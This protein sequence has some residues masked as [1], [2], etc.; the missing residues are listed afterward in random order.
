MSSYEEYM[1]TPPPTTEPTPEPI[2]DGAVPVNSPEPSSSTPT[3]TYDQPPPDTYQAPAPEPTPTDTYNDYESPPPTDT[4]QAPPPSPEPTP[5]D[6]YDQP[7]ADTYQAPPPDISLPPPPPDEYE[8]PPPTTQ[9]QSPDY[10]GGPI[11]SEISSPDLSKDV[12]SLITTGDRNIG[13]GYDAG[14]SLYS[15]VSAPDLMK[16]V[17]YPT[18][19]Y[20]GGSIGTKV[21]APDL[22]KD[23]S[24][25][26]FGT[27]KAP[28]QFG[29]EYEFAMAG[30]PKA[31]TP[32]QDYL[33]DWGVFT[34]SDL[35]KHGSA[36]T[37]RKARL[38]YTNDDFWL[39]TPKDLGRQKGIEAQDRELKELSDLSIIPSGKNVKVPSLADAILEPKSTFSKSSAGGDYD[40]FGGGPF[41]GPDITDRILGSPSSKPQPSGD[42]DDFGG[43]PTGYDITKDLGS[44]PSTR[45]AGGFAIGF[46]LPDSDKDFMGAKAFGLSTES[47]MRTDDYLS[48]IPIP[49]GYTPPTSVY[50][51]PKLSDLSPTNTMR[52]DNAK[53]DQILAALKSNTPTPAGFGLTQ[54]ELQVLKDR[55]VSQGA[56]ASLTDKGFSVVF[57][58]Q[59]TIS[60]TQGLILLDLMKQGKDISDRPLN[61]VDLTYLKDLAIEKG[62]QPTLTSKGFSVSFPEE[63]TIS[64]GQA[65]SIL[66]Q[67]MGGQTPSTPL[68]SL[69]LKYLRDVAVERGYNASLTD[70]GLSVTFGGKATSMDM[71]D[72][73]APAPSSDIIVHPDEFSSLNLTNLGQMPGVKIEKLADGGYTINYKQTLSQLD[74]KTAGGFT[75]D[76]AEGQRLNDYAKGLSAKGYSEAEIVEALRSQ[77]APKQEAFRLALI[78]SGKTSEEA[79]KLARDLF[80]VPYNY[81]ITTPLRPPTIKSK[82]DL[83]QAEG[84]AER[85]LSLSDVDAK[86]VMDDMASYIRTI[87]PGRFGQ[88]VPDL[89]AGVE[90]SP[91]L[92]TGVYNIGIGAG[93]NNMLDFN[94]NRGESKVMTAG[95]GIPGLE[96]DVKAV[97]G[98]ANFLDESLGITKTVVG[99][100]NF[101]DQSLG[102]S[103]FGDYFAQKVKA[104]ASKSFNPEAREMADKAILESPV[105]NSVVNFAKDEVDYYANSPL[106]ILSGERSVGAILGA[107]GL[108]I[109]SSPQAQKSSL[110]YLENPANW[111][112]FAVDLGIQTAIYG[113]ALPKALGLAGEVVSKVGPTSAASVKYLSGLPDILKGATMGGGISGGITF[114]ATGDPIEAGK[115]AVLGVI[116]GG[117]IPAIG[118]AI[119]KYGEVKVFGE[120][121]YKGIYEQVGSEA[122]PLIGKIYNR[123]IFS[124]E[125][126][127]RLGDEAR[128]LISK[129]SGGGIRLGTPSLKD[130]ILPTPE[131]GYIPTS[132]LETKIMLRPEVYEQLG[133]PV[134]EF[135]KAE[136][137]VGLGKMYEKTPSE[138][139]VEKFKRETKNISPE[140]VDVLMENFRNDKLVETVGGSFAQR[141]QMPEAYQRVPGDIDINLNTA[142]PKVAARFVKRQAE[143]LR[144]VGDN[145]EIPADDPLHIYNKT[146]GGKALE[147][148]YKGQ[149][150]E[151]GMSPSA[152]VDQRFGFDVNQPNIKVEGIPT[153]RLGEQL[154]RKV[155]SS[156]EMRDMMNEPFFEGFS[157]RIFNERGLRKTTSLIERID[158]GQKFSELEISKMFDQSDLRSESLFKGKTEDIR[159]EPAPHRTKDIVDAYFVAKTLAESDRAGF[160]G[161]F[162]QAKYTKGLALAEEWKELY[163]INPSTQHNF[164]I[165]LVESATEGK[166][167]TSMTYA[168]RVFTSPLSLPSPPASFTDT[169]RGTSSS[170]ST[171]KSKKSQTSADSLLETPK[172]LPKMGIEQS[173]VYRSSITPDSLLGSLS[174]SILDTKSFISPSTSRP[175][176]K[177]TKSIPSSVYESFSHSIGSQH[178]STPSMPSI[179]SQ[180]PSGKSSK[181]SL[182]RQ[183]SLPQSSFLPPPSRSPPPSSLP[184]PYISPP[185]Q[186]FPPPYR[187]P[188]KIP[189][190]PPPSP[191]SSVPRSPPPSP[192]P[193]FFPPPSRPP[194]S[195]IP[196]PYKPPPPYIPSRPPSPPSSVPRSPPSPPPSIP[197]VPPPPRVEVPRLPPLF[198]GGGGAGGGPRGSGSRFQKYN[199]NNPFRNPLILEQNFGKFITGG[200]STSGNKFG[201]QK[202]LYRNPAKQDDM[203]K[204]LTS[205]TM[206]SK[207]TRGTAKPAS[208]LMSLSASIMGGKTKGKK[209]LRGFAE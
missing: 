17:S 110:E 88:T 28:V 130:V 208:R 192:P 162:R 35:L 126:V 5:T 10:F 75:V 40:D 76:E 124:P 133:V 185:P 191:P 94:P 60:K 118:K 77:L 68:N 70:K 8:S 140:G 67:M 107:T 38:D 3:D 31:N 141:V 172:S 18:D 91:G 197:R 24:S 108:P 150:L 171:T 111:P 1:T 179:I 74:V 11:G 61:T 167:K 125:E 83:F 144:K 29:N 109:I 85:Y 186:S 173:S 86:K 151:E 166:A 65:S 15:E 81:D 165:P 131:R 113:L 33:T 119:P 204:S 58:E 123:T 114:A 39:G 103:Q 46:G 112:G 82:G 161:S 2:P 152:G 22:T 148:H 93:Y 146:T 195:K 176:S 122:H 4:Y 189:K 184:P 135:R 95:L 54:A 53:A 174:S 57:P 139:I 163:G 89:Q 156:L 134:G 180:P 202:P 20:L 50:N 102:I 63:Q 92:G 170:P 209:F 136:V 16:G 142:D 37:D 196:P 26:I 47:S 158:T 181:I 96:R 72:D 7:P 117:G 9:I 187:P 30:S 193:S 190:S 49:K 116:L 143:S 106:R 160:L 203:L 52:L 145:V 154:I 121:V 175:S 200:K 66:D 127:L 157:V 34:G 188:S 21:S 59:Q 159:L 98:G 79:G 14:S 23:L 155:S 64:K 42:Y 45:D 178:G 120:P 43:A 62:Y 201:E 41:G 69:D 194:P 169:L 132:A 100:A 149:P 25:D 147:V 80:F 177:G 182:P 27:F 44:L 56:Q 137:G 84:V 55:A 99:G 6:T 207:T 104:N 128:P 101:L 73:Y 105:Y 138:F 205:S 183:I 32:S 115:S 90:R 206:G 164:K 78:E 51:Y 36:E 87:E 12:G 199:I 48:G 198:L 13:T 153:Q 97:V 168:G 129:V 71:L 19:D